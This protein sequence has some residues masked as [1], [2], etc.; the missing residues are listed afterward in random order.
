MGNR[1]LHLIRHGDYLEGETED[2]LGNGLSGRG[3]QQAGKLAEFYDEYRLAAIHTSPAPRAVET[4]RTIA[5]RHP[6]L[7]LQ[8]HRSLFE[9]IPSVPP[10]VTP[11]GE[12][13]E[14]SPGAVSNCRKRLDRQF[15]RSFKSTGAEERHE[16]FVCH[17][18]V[19]RYFVTRALDVDVNSWVSMRCSQASVTRVVV[20]S[21]T[22]RFVLESLNDLS[23][24]PANL[25]AVDD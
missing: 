15:D 2:G 5:E 13:D 21:G 12:P 1:I 19:I 18:N 20:S 16:I 25:R 10:N 9:C 4:A 17:G 7:A 3:Q 8:R 23:H 24:L 14:L 11:W 6:G 22:P